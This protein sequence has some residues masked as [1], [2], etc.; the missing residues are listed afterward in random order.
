MERIFSVS[1][2]S[3]PVD[4]GLLT[5]RVGISVF[6][7]HHGYGKMQHFTEMQEKFINFFGFSGS[8][9]LCLI[10]FAELFCS[11]AVLVGLLTRLA[12]VPLVIT[13]LVALIVA[14]NGEAFGDG[15]SATIYLIIYISLLLAGPGRYSLDAAFTSKGA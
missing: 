2:A 3:T 13:M 14:H 10:I 1:Q 9:S 6:M 4:L 5:L 8:I 15:E 11:I 7:I 12:L